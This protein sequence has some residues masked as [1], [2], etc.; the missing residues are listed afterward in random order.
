M[1][2]G[3]EIGEELQKSSG[4]LQCSLEITEVLDVLQ[5]S[6]LRYHS[7]D[8]QEVPGGDRKGAW[9]SRRWKGLFKSFSP[10]VYER[11]QIGKLVT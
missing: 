1:V 6:R 4:E 3:V 9:G 11:T 8:V 5:T 10:G 7:S 2:I